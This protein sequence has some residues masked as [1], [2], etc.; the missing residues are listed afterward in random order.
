MF[1]LGTFIDGADEFVGMVLDDKV[2][3]LEQI[4]CAWVKDWGASRS[5]ARRDSL[6]ALVGDWDR[7]FPFL[8][9]MAEFAR[10]RIDRFPH[11]SLST[12]RPCPPIR[13]PGKIL[14]SAAN[15]R[16]H[17]A[18]MAD[19]NVIQGQVDSGLRFNGDKDAARPYLFLKASNALNGAF[20]PIVIPKDEGVQI[21]WEAEVAVVIGRGGRNISPD[22]A[23]SHIA[24]YMAANDITRR[25]TLWRHDRPNFKTDWLASKSTDGFLPIGPV[26]MPAA[27]VPDP[28]DLHIT[29]TVNGELKQSGHVSDMIFSAEEQISFASQFMTLE[30]GDIFVTGTVGGVGQ[31]SGTYLKVGDVVETEISRVG[32]MCNRIV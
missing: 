25:D 28:D 26:L 24:G 2:I 23:R 19:Y 5:L 18:E 7:A 17:V 21:D 22:A 3:S 13:R 14:H 27:F 32:R 8:S 20:E 6:L 16:E 10:A 30:P 12:S 9:E 31:A 29:L 11:G 15:F 4:H 1:A